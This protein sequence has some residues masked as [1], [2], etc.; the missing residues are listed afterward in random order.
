L[1]RRTDRAGE[2]PCDR[3]RESR[4]R[5][6]AAPEPRRY[7]AVAADGRWLF[8]AAGSTPTS[9]AID[10]VLRVD[11]RTGTVERFAKLLRPISHAAAFVQHGSLFVAGGREADGRTRV[12]EIERVDLRSRA[13]AAAGRL[14]QARSDLAVVV[15]GG[16]VFAIGGRTASGASNLVGVL[17]PVPA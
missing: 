8:V 14:A 3:D 6:A 15:D 5:R 4:E 13:V 1:Q 17:E 11:V 2:R 7:A 16:R 9:A 12:D 10:D